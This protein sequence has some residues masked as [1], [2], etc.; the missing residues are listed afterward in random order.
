VSE[1]NINLFIGGGDLA[2]IIG[3]SDDNELDGLTATSTSPE[4][5]EVHRQVI[6][7]MRTR[8]LFVLHPV[9][10]KPGIF[11]AIFE[12][13]CGRREIVVRLK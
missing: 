8:A 5:V 11:Q 2:V 3:R 1:E 13:P 7:G 10:T 6:E 9:G 12:M 4:N